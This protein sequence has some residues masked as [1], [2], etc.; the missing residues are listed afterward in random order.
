MHSVVKHKAPQKDFI[1]YGNWSI[2]K[3][4]QHLNIFTDDYCFILSNSY[5]LLL[6]FILYIYLSIHLFVSFFLCLFIYLFI[7][8]C[9]RSAHHQTVK[10]LRFRPVVGEVGQSSSQVLQLAS[11]GADHLVRIYR[12][13][14]DA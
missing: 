12:F 4:P 5:Y 8:V 10:R 3:E 7:F 6:F 14:M 2:Q 1:S 11:C 13:N 9:F